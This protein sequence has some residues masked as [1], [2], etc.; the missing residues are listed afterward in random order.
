MSNE[1][2]K[3]SYVHLVTT[4]P[5][6]FNGLAKRNE[7]QMYNLMFRVTAQLVKKLGLDPAHLGAQPGLI[8]VLHTFGSNMDY[9]VHIHSMM[10]F[11]GIDKAG[12]WKYPKHK[13]RLCRNSKLRQTFKEVFLIELKKLFDK[14]LL[15]YHQDYDT[16]IEG[17]GNKSWTVFSTHPTMETSTIELYLARYINR[18]AVTNSRLEYIKSNNEVHLLYNDYKNQEQGKVAPKKTRIMTGIEFL[19]Q[20]LMHLPPPYFHRT[21]RYGI[22]A[23]SKSKE[24]KKC[25]S[26]KLKRNGRTIR[27]VMEIISHLMH[28]S[29]F[30]CEQCKGTEFIKK[31]L[32]PDKEWKYKWLTL[33]N[34]RAPDLRPNITS[35]KTK[36]IF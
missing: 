25:I 7:Q 21:R 4:M 13:K 31:D 34:I 6:D 22:H 2:F 33:P 1:L 35:Y 15:E 36:P 23:S 16:L 11:G 8:S 32:F 17:L 20:L 10:T 3:V 9:H 26:E 29:P 28:L 14:D 27:T 18:I 19:N 30:E 5:H 24:V 12:E